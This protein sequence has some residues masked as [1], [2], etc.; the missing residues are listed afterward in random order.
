[1]LG[2]EGGFEIPD[3]YYIIIYHKK[4]FFSARYI[5]L[6]TVFTAD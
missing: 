6:L 1:M 2:H 5:Y 4:V 3:I